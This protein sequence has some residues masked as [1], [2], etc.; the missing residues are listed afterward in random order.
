MTKV[1]FSSQELSLSKVWRWYQE[2]DK[3]LDD[4]Q[5]EIINT[6]T[7]EISVSVF[8]GMAKNEIIEEF[9]WQKNELDRLVSFNLIASAEASLRIDYLT[10][11][12]EK[13]KDIISR[14]F[15]TL[16]KQKETRAALDNDI[17]KIWKQYYPACKPAISNFIGALNLRHWLAHGRYWTPKFGRDYNPKYVFDI[18][19]NLFNVL[20][21]DF[22]WAI[23]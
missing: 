6:R 4:Y 13:R 2:M 22:S 17:L 20:P 9:T 18:I 12:Y 19:E 11:V 3:A 8:F 15:R 23:D 1:S 16:Y 14:E 5:T 7:E 21:D 10:R